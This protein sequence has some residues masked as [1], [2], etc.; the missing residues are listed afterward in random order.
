MREKSEIPIQS[1]TSLEETK[2]DGEIM[3]S[4]VCRRKDELQYGLI[5]PHNMEI[6]GYQKYVEKYF[7]IWHLC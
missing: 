6:F 5:Y 7:Y 4:F 2:E 1:T 3:E